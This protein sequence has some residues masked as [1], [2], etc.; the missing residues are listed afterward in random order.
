MRFELVE[1]S[2]LIYIF[3]PILSVRLITSED[4]QNCYLTAFVSVQ[5]SLLTQMENLTEEGNQ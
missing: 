2:K 1:F 5:L 4:N 3:F